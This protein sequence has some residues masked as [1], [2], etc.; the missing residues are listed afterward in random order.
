MEKCKYHQNEEVK[1]SCKNCGKGICQKCY[2][3]LDDIDKH[4]YLHNIFMEIPKNTCMS[5]TLFNLTNYK[6]IIDLEEKEIVNKYIFILFLYV[7]G[8]I[9]FIVSAILESFFIILGFFLCGYGTW[10]YYDEGLLT[11]KERKDLGVENYEITKGVSGY[12]IKQAEPDSLVI[13]AVFLW[14]IGI[15]STPIYLLINIR[16]V[17]RTHD[18]YLYIKNL[19][20]KL[21]KL[22]HKKYV[23]DKK[24]QRYIETK[25]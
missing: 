1:Y 6:E 18:T 9:V 17:K 21:E 4:T 11:L 3:I 10:Y 5:C 19:I 22:T 2:D 8:I 25:I 15:I 24:R 16:K 7:I 23:Y 13:V 12:N 14:L 20:D